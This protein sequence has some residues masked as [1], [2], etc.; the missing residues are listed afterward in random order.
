MSIPV[1][2]NDQLFRSQQIGGAILL[3]FDKTV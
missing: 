3:I 1:A 2:G